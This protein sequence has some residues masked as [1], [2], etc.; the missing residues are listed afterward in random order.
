M[1]SHSWANLLDHNPSSVSTN[2]FLE[3]VSLPDL[4]SIR[5]ARCDC[6]MVEQSTIYG[7]EAIVVSYKRETRWDLW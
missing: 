1:F 4:R 3:V 7:V 6:L 5:T 2:T